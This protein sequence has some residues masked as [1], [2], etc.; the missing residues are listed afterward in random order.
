MM[1]EHLFVYG[2]LLKG[3]LDPEVDEIIDKYCKPINWGYIN[4]KL[5]DLG[6]YPGAIL[7]IDDES[8]IYGLLY[9]I[10][11]PDIFFFVLD[12]Y[13][14]Y[15]PGDLARSEYIRR[16]TEVR[17]NEHNEQIR[18]W[19]YEYNKSI[20]SSQPYIESGNWLEHLK[21]KINT[22]II[23][24]KR[25]KDVITIGSGWFF[26]FLGV[27]GLFLPFL[28]GILFLL[29]GLF[30][31]SKKARWARSILMKLKKRYPRIY[32][33]AQ[34]KW[35]IMKQYIKQILRKPL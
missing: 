12:D 25:L 4:G 29:I 6:D 35:D 22:K 17:L 9:E 20:T 8:F 31:L 26:I 19:V 27:A 13:E 14:D 1:K 18:A 34:K 21:C 7:S 32:L 3:A 30:I 23:I 15:F 33:N 11:S 2:S 24:K 16:K 5:F 28:Q 10:S